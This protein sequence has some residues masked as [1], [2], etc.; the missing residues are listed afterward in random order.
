MMFLYDYT[1]PYR[2]SIFQ[3]EIPI[4][5]LG[6]GIT[7]RLTGGGTS[8][9]LQ[10]DEAA[11]MGEGWSDALAEWALLDQEPVPDFVLATWVL[12][13]PK[14]IRSAPYSTNHDV[15]SLMYSTIKTLNE[16]HDYGEVWAVTLHG[17]LSALVDEH[18][19]SEDAKTDPS[20]TEGNI[21]FF[22]LFIDSLSLQPCNPTMLNARDAWLQ[23]DENRYDGANKCL[24][25]AAFADRGMGPNASSDYEDDTSV[26]E[27]C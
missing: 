10:T 11:G 15:N 23:A 4:H 1:N 16:A 20:G 5:E 7:N 8:R 6:H 25:W 21:V 9:C 14:G 22:H 19:F 13:D 27:G 24:I 17:I 26:P 12:D 18:G 2:D 3:N